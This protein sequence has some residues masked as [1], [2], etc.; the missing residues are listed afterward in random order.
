MS[1]GSEKVQRKV[2]E[3]LEVIAEEMAQKADQLVLK[4]DLEE[5]EKRYFDAKALV[6]DSKNIN[7]KL[8]RF[9][10]D[11]GDEQKGLDILTE[12]GMVAYAKRLYPPPV[13]DGVLDDPC[14]TKVKP[15]TTF[16]QCIDNMVAYPIEGKSE[17]YVGYAHGSLF[18]GIKG[19]EPS[20]KT[21]TAKRTKRDDWVPGD[22][23]VEIFMDTNH[24]YKTYYQIIVNS[25]GTVLDVY[26]AG[27]TRLGS[28]EWN[29]EYTLVTKVEDTF[30]S[31]EI[32]IPFKPLG[33]AQVGRGTVWG[34]NVA[35]VRIGN[36]SEY[37]QWVPTYG[38]AHRPGRFGFLFFE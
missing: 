2:R 9:Y 8:G 31:F 24:D 38:L 17:A 5:A 32:E 11:N 18:V 37:G 33:D 13:I 22:D 30:W 28:P 29:G 23:C 26:N 35:R 25:L 12:Y 16:Y 19:Y 3:W 6:P 14:W 1:E 21:L 7:Q 15:L 27:D 10:F 34:F 36:A 20:T 4:G